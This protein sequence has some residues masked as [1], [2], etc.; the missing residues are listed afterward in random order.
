MNN[1]YFDS[2]KFQDFYDNVDGNSKRG[3]LRL[4]WYG[5]LFGDVEKPVVEAKIKSGDLGTKRTLRTEPFC[6]QEKFEPA[7]LEDLLEKLPASASKP[8]LEGFRPTLVNNYV[9]RYYLS[10]DQRFR[11]TVDHSLK[12]YKI[13]LSK[14]AVLTP[15]T[16]R[17]KIIIELKYDQAHSDAAREVTRF[18]PFRVTKNSKYVS[19]IRKTF[20]HLAENDD[21]GDVF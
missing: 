13:G 7:I 12:Y 21:L 9:R 11:I 20:Y 17:R 16:D 1:I 10:A 15:L 5:N 4:R 2:P 8:F 18:L 14:V 19:G 3:K 6:M